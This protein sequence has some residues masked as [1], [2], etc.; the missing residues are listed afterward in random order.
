[1]VGSPDWHDFPPLTLYPERVLYR[2]HRTANDPVYFCSDGTGRFDVTNVDGIGTC[3]VTPSPMGAYIETL[4]RLGAISE[5]D[6]AERSM[7]ELVLIRPLKLAD[8]TNRQGLGSHRI[9]GDISVGTDYAAS[10]AVASELYAAGF[11]GVYYTARHDPAFQERSVAIF[12][13]P[14]DTKLFATARNE[15]PDEVLRQG[16]IEFDLWILPD[17]Y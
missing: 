7:S 2:V 16:A 3:Y 8:L 6:I 12:G 10:Q 13:G 15:I 5:S 17:L 9:T 4:G 11:D 14:G 1:M